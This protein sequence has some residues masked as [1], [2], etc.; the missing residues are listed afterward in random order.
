[1]K[2]MIFQLL[3]PE[4]LNTSDVQSVQLYTAGVHEIHNVDD[5]IIE[6]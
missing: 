6:L 2:V 1:M 5:R 4:S 3:C